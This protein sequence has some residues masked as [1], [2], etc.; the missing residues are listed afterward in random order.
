MNADT[1]RTLLEYNYAAHRRLWDGIAC[2]T[3]E[4]FVQEVDYSIG[5]VRNHMVHLI[6]VDLRWLARLQNAALPERL[7]ENGFTTVEAARRKWAEVES[8]VLAYADVLHDADLNEIIYYDMPHRGGAKRNPRWEILVH[9]VN[10]GTDHRAQVLPILHRLSAP[11]FEQDL[12]I[13]LW[14]KGR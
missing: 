1:I 14:D 5:S 12:M 11:T 6:N 4:Q 8:A 2:L 7:S 10:H 3:D 9:V 13:Y